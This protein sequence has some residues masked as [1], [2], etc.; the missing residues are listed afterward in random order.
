[1]PYRCC[2]CGGAHGPKKC[3]IPPGVHKPTMIEVKD[4]ITGQISKKPDYIFKCV[5][6]NKE[7]HAANSR[8]CP[9]RQSRL[10]KIK[11]DAV[12]KNNKK[13]TRQNRF[14]AN[15][16][17]VKLG[18]SFAEITKQNDLSQNTPTHN[19][20][21]NT[22]DRPMTDIM[23]SFENFDQICKKNFGND[24]FSCL[25]KVRKYAKDLNSVNQDCQAKAMIGI[26]TS[27]CSDD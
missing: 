4:P 6:C 1:M 12:P 22:G 15:S 7:G 27:L 14:S 21:A 24:F 23:T 3:H 19:S 18:V 17:K 9:I 25:A 20:V 26:L 8:E 13:A 11:S 2:K 5:N 16:G 10:A